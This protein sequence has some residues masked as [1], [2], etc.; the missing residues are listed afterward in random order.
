MSRR[1]TQRGLGTLSTRL[2]TACRI[3]THQRLVAAFGHVS[4]RIPRSGHLLI[5]PR[6][7][8]GTATRKDLLVVDLLG[9]VQ[10]GTSRPPL[11][12]SIHTAIYRSRP[13]VEAICRVHGEAASVLSIL[14]VPV[15]PMHYL[16]SILG[17][18]VPVHDDGSLVTDD[19]RAQAM[20]STLGDAQALLLRGNGQVVVGASLAEACVRAIYL[21][22]AA[23]LQMAAMS[24]G[25]PRYY[26]PEEIAVYAGEWKD[27]IN[28]QRVW[29]F[30]AGLLPRAE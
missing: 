16:G 19:A 15:R 5:S 8:P 21:E 10:R 26:S 3:L 1:R 25:T 2:V 24:L 23:R 20:A 27:P 7:G 11:E 14:R 18:E 28:I 12:L 6:V 9:H 17:G 22:E 30:Y 29:R 13:S 4:A